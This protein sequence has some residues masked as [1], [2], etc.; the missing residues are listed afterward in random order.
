MEEHAKST[1]FGMREKWHI[2]VFHINIWRYVNVT[3]KKKRWR[4]ATGTV[5]IALA[6][7]SRFQCWCLH[8]ISD[9]F[10]HSRRPF[11]HSS[12]DC[13]RCCIRGARAARSLHCF[14][15]FCYL[16]VSAS[17]GAHP[18]PSHIHAAVCSLG[19]RTIVRRRNSWYLTHVSHDTE[20]SVSA[21]FIVQSVVVIVLCQTIQW[22]E[23]TRGLPCVRCC[24]GDDE[25][26]M[27]WYGRAFY[28]R[29]IV[30]FTVYVLLLFSRWFFFV[31]FER[32]LRFVRLPWLHVC[33][34]VVDGCIWFRFVYD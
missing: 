11:A 2:I 22:A 20:S 16:A 14:V 12:F 34:F 28:L 13:D 7:V 6:F 21:R 4:M 19:T 30:L 9:I 3:K 18:W 31:L 15:L 17:P 5:A 29:A 1:A 27:Q 32:S 8:F 25:S 33:V 23:N 24:V 10:F 26:R